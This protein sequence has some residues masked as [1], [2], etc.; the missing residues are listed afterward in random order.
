MNT[1]IIG[2]I[3]LQLIL[4][5]INA[6]FAC[7]EI[8]VI[9]VNDAK[10][11]KLAAE[12]N[13][14]AIRLAKLKNKPARF[15]S[16]IQVAITLSGF[17]G[18]AFA[19]QNFADL[20]MIP[21]KK[22][23]IPIPDSVLNTI[24]V[25]L[26][27]IILSY[28]TLVFGELVPKRVAMKKAESIALGISGLISF[29]SVLFAPIVWLLTISTNGVLRLMGIDPNA[30]DEEVT[31]QDIRMMVDVGS[32]KGVIDD[33]EKEMIQNV[34][35]FDD[36]TIDKFLTHRTD[37]VY[38][39]EED[40]VDVWHE[41]ICENPHACYPICGETVDDVT[42]V[43]YANDY[44]RLKDRS[45]K[46]AIIEG[47]VRSPYFVPET[48]SADVLFEQMKKTGNYFAVAL[49]E[50]GGMSGIV[51]LTNLIEQIVGDFPD[52]DTEDGEIVEDEEIK[53]LGDRRFRILGSAE[54]D[55]VSETIGVKLPADEFDTFGGYV[56][57][58]YGTVPDDGTTISVDT[59]D[60]HIEVLKI[61]EHRAEINEVTVLEKAAVEEQE[62][63]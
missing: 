56:F 51:T 24:C 49:D 15:L 60:L 4:I 55:E 17:L 50:Y 7:T 16:T 10:L 5:A 40:G 63:V 3:L 44:F 19:S 29:V 35:E 45:T 20:L 22:L 12:G 34:F 32:E 11:A 62:K 31:E 1:D 53:K 39:Y 23:N 21:L 48:L 6:I 9:S 14:K 42:G 27:T 43:L 25:V 13:K 38:L 26:I 37:I 46:E 28:I 54:L 52:D 47:A 59:E 58:I 36:L 33:S 2:Q 41:T 30:D 61:N 57:G 8:A 18:S